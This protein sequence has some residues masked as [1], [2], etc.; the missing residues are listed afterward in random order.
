[1]PVADSSNYSLRLLCTA[2]VVLS[3]A[4]CPSHDT[5]EAHLAAAA[6]HPSGYLGT[7]MAV[8]ERLRISVTAE[9]HSYL[10]L[11]VGRHNKHQFIGLFGTWVGLPRLHSP[12]KLI[13]SVSWPAFSIK[14]FCKASSASAPHEPFAFL[15]CLGFLLLQMSPRIAMRHAYCSLNAL[16]DGRMWTLITSNFLHGNPAHLLHNVLNVL[17]LGPVVASALG[18][19]RATMLLGA[20]M[21]TTSLASVVWHGVLNHRPGGGSVG[22]SGVTMALLAANAALY[23]NVRVT[24]YGIQLDAYMVPLMHLILDVLSARSGG[25]AQGAN[26]IDVS[27][28][29]GGAVAGWVLGLRWRPW[30]YL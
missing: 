25:A 27:A 29:L 26:D 3:V 20:A 9:S 2:V 30:F 7:V 24:M 14:G 16:R 4:T 13:G 6:S 1:M 12:L 22:A 8:A 5:F 15:C 23:P 10:L 19:E 17:H 28:H 18:C 11:R 21:L